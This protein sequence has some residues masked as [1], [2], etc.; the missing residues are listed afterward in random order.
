MCGIS[1]L[2]I[3]HPDDVPMVMNIDTL[4]PLIIVPPGD[5]KVVVFHDGGYGL[6]GRG[7]RFIRTEDTKPHACPS[8]TTGGGGDGVSIFLRSNK[9]SSKNKLVLICFSRTNKSITKEIGNVGFSKK[10][11]FDL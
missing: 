11:R 3:I 8:H 5:A 4:E 1:Y 9:P 10:V 6:S 2:L 7:V